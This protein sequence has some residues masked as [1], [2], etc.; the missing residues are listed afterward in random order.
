MRKTK[1][2]GRLFNVEGL[3][4][5]EG[6][7]VDEVMGAVIVR[8]RPKS[9]EQDRCPV[10]RRKC[11]RY[12]AGSGVRRWRAH[13]LGVTMAYVEGA[14]PRVSC[15]EH[16]VVVAAVPWARHDSGF[17]RDFEDH[18]AWLAVHTSKSAVS[19]LMR[20]AWA[21]VA[22]IVQR[23]SADRAAKVDRFAKLRR[24]G[25]DEISYK[26]GHRYI[27]TVVDHDTGRLV[28]AWPGKDEMALRLF[29][30]A[31][32]KE[33]SAKIELVS[34]DASAA[35]TNVIEERCPNA[36]ACM[37]PFH[38]VKWAADALDEARRTTW[39]ELRQ[40]GQAAL[41]RKLKNSRYALWKDPADL[42]EAQEAKLSFIQSA[43]RPLYRAYLLK[44]QLREV[45]KVGGDAG[46]VL[47]DA[48]LSW[49]CR[50]RI[51]AFVKLSQKIRRHRKAIDAALEHGLSNARVE[52]MNTGIRLLTRI[53][54]GFHQVS[55]LIAL[56]SLKFG[57]LCPPLPG[58]S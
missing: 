3:V 5:V 30:V 13:D 23:V 1:L 40:G 9:R 29:F 58:R 26:K 24:I 28:Y 8:M 54:F 11:G 48:W 39:N 56:A 52:A 38:V 12:D 43:N 37:D 51:P 46:R 34:R 6:V 55:S 2:W 15:A 25:V 45:F 14:A 44:E 16:G 42:T 36:V 20:V 4:V 7:E 47:L 57:G 18:V 32:G 17:L 31:L 21:T 53:A 41:A 33:R 50:C 35:Y 49:A 10:C 19:E 27:T 22:R